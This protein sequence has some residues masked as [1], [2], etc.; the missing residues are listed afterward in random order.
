MA[1]IKSVH[2]QADSDSPAHR[3]EDAP[4]HSS[5]QEQAQS[6]LSD[7]AAACTRIK[8][9]ELDKMLHRHQRYSLWGSTAFRAVW[10]QEASLLATNP[11][12]LFTRG[13]ANSYMVI[14]PRLTFLP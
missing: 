9:E 10:W 6:D 2:S 14:E 1:L 8:Q 11:S 5:R 4:S 3:D 7:I 12:A 13:T